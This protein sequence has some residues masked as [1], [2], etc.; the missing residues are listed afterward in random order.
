VESALRSGSQRRV[1]HVH[2]HALII[3]DNDA[4]DEPAVV[5]ADVE[6]PAA[7]ALEEERAE[8]RRPREIESRWRP[9]VREAAFRE[10][11][12]LR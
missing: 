3:A 11:L 6:Q 2:S 5:T 8:T 12:S 10:L 9:G 7:R 1:R 4:R